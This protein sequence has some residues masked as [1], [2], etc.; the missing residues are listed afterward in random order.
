MVGKEN[1]TFQATQSQPRFSSA[2]LQIN[3]KGDG[4]L[5]TAPTL[6]GHVLMP[7]SPGFLLLPYDLCTISSIALVS[8]KCA[9]F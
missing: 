2:A 5:L 3:I 7:P 6:P 4:C 9:S 8:Y 1:P